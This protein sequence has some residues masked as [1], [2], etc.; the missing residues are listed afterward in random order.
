M[1]LHIETKESM[2]DG[3]VEDKLTIPL[4]DK[5]NCLPLIPDPTDVDYYVKKTTE[6]LYMSYCNDFW[7]CLQNVAKGIWRDEL[8]ISEVCKKVTYRCKGNILINSP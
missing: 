3:Y 6:S 8:S 1:D 2:M 7:W 4:L 5:D